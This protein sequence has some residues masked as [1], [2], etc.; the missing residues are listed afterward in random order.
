MAIEYYNY[1][2]L[3]REDYDATYEP[4]LKVHDVEE[5]RKVNSNSMHLFDSNMDA[6]L[7]AIEYIL[8]LPRLQFDFYNLDEELISAAYDESHAIIIVP[9]SLFVHL[10]E[11]FVGPYTLIIY[12]DN[13]IAEVEQLFGIMNSKLGFIRVSQ[14]NQTLLNEHWMTLKKDIS[15]ISYDVM[16]LLPQYLMAGETTKVLP[17]MFLAR[18][19]NNVETILQKVYNTQYV[20]KICMEEQWKQVAH[21]NTLIKLKERN[22]VEEELIEE[23]EYKY[24][25]E[26]QNDNLEVVITFPGVPYNQ[27]KYG[28]LLTRLPENEKKAIRII[29]LHRAIAKNGVLLEITCAN[30]EIFEKLNQLELACKRYTNNKYVLKALKELGQMFES[31]LTPEQL[32]CVKKAKHLTIFSD[33][34]VGLAILSDTEVP[35]Q[36][37][38]SISYRSLSPLTRALSVEMQKC[39]IY[40]LQQ[41]CK[42]VF[43]ECVLPDE[44]NRYVRAQSDLLKNQLIELQN[45]YANMSFSYME[46]YTIHD[47]KLF[48]NSNKDADILYISAHGVYQ[49]KNNMAGLMI[50]EEFWIADDNGLKVPPVVLLSAC[51]VSPRGSGAVN[52]ADLFLRAGA[53]TV[54]GTFIPVNAKRNTIL[55]L[56]LFIYILEGQKGSAQYETLAD[57]WTGVVA[58][59]AI[60]ELMES[61]PS[62]RKWMHSN[63]SEGRARIIDFQ[64][65][66]SVGR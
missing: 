47:L 18:Q 41:K 60:H 55:M 64:L 5:L 12:A 56:R 29:G 26:L 1:L 33:F 37:Y 20:E 21:Q 2:I 58:S 40:N 49:R 51:H 7:P 31:F 25:Q 4:V 13:C 11:M 30:K 45:E 48:L 63:N 59:N 57:A 19:Y 24:R 54:L 15:N 46:T 32:M 17:L 6:I 3:F 52:V 22:I 50:G 9:D 16:D 43:A 28:G 39:N 42:I 53:V 38:K 44:K 61:S 35:L 62:F 23:Y 27:V 65:F 34:P 8:H 66:R 36:C 10:S 14:L